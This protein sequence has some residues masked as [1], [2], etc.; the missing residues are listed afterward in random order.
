MVDDNRRN[1]RLYRRE[2]AEWNELLC[3]ARPDVET[4]QRPSVELET[5]IKL[6]NHMVL[7]HLCEEGCDLALA[8]GIVDGVIDRLDADTESRGTRAVDHQRGA[9]RLGLCGCTDVL[10]HR[11]CGPGR[12]HF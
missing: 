7:T 6:L 1:T 11:H 9:G 3:C 5:R 12:F 4:L 2:N 8:E 10:Q